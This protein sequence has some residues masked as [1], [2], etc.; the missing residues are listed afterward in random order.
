MLALAGTVAAVAAA[1]VHATRVV[2]PRCA[3]GGLVVWMDTQGN[4]TA[5]SSFFT[6]R[7][8]NLS[9]RACTLLGY[10]GVSA[11][12]LH[13]RQV[14]K[15]ATRE[16]M[17]ARVVS[18]ARGATATAILRIVDAD[19]FPAGV[20]RQVTAAGLRVYPPGQRTAKTIP[21]PFRACSR[22]AG[23]AYLHVRPVK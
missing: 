3:T 14:G 2:A 18:V 22:A 6:L 9:G 15:A 21:F 5:G 13:G 4:G 1:Q 8:T 19:N 11:V 23:P 10:P 20:C 17:R 12:D 16:P 7:F